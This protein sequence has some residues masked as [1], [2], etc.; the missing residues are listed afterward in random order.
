MALTRSV[1]TEQR[2]PQSGRLQDPG[3]RGIDQIIS[4]SAKSGSSIGV[5]KHVASK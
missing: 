4:D 3:D 5:L 1:A 2:R